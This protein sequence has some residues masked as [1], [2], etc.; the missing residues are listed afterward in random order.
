MNCKN[1]NTSLTLESD[2]YN[3]CGAK[4]IRNRLTIKNLFE[5]LIETY[6]NYDNKFLQ[7]FIGLIKCPENVIGSYVFGVRK[8]Y[9]NPLSFLAI[10]LTLSGI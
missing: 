7:T 5:H 1:C 6:L 10:S 9:I 8:K 4:V 3:C 2:F